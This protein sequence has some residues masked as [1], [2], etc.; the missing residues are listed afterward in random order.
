[1]LSKLLR[2]YVLLETQRL[3]VVEISPRH[4]SQPLE[5]IQGAISLSKPPHIH[6]KSGHNAMDSWYDNPVSSYSPNN[7]ILTKERR[8]SFQTASSD[9]KEECLEAQI[10]RL[11]ELIGRLENKTLWFDLHQRLSDS[12][13]TACAYLLLV[14]SEMTVSQ[15]HLGEFCASLKQYLKTVAGEQDCFQ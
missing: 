7:R 14:R 4:A 6:S 3:I 10:N 9:T 12:E 13:N 15:K 8:K 11:A 2:V 5:R 1:M